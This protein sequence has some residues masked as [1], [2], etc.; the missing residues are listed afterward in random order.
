M[1]KEIAKKFVYQNQLSAEDA[2]IILSEYCMKFGE[3]TITPQQLQI[4][5]QLSQMIPWIRLLN[6][7]GKNENFYIMEIYSQEDPNTHVRNL[8]A[9]TLYEYE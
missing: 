2:G 5:L 7:L 3:R 9:R 6:T 8:V 4:M 1:V